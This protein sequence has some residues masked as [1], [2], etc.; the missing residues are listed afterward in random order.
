[1]PHVIWLFP[2]LYC[3]SCDENF[4]ALEPCNTNPHPLCCLQ[5]IG[6]GVQPDDTVHASTYHHML[7]IRKLGTVI[8]HMYPIPI[9]IQH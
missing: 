4:C 1:M 8:Q 9:A 7:S 3:T 6:D 2:A 5:D